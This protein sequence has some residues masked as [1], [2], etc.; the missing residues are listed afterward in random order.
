M[1]KKMTQKQLIARHIKK[2]GSI[3]KIVARKRYGV[4]NLRARMCELRDDL[5]DLMPIFDVIGTNYVYTTLKRTPGS[6][7]VKIGVYTKNYPK[8]PVY[9]Y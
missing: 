1:K 8:T 3:T 2:N 6:N 7:G 9:F 5:A 4:Q